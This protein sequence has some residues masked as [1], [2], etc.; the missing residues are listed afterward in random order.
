MAP[1]VASAAACAAPSRCRRPQCLRGSTPWRPSTRGSP[2]RW[3]PPRARATRPGMRRWS[4]SPS[5]WRAAMR[6]CRRCARRACVCRCRAAES[7]GPRCSGMVAPW[8]GLGVS[9]QMSPPLA[10]PRAPRAAQDPTAWDAA[11]VETDVSIDQDAR[12]RVRSARLVF[13]PAEVPAEGA[14]L[15]PEGEPGGEPVA[16]GAQGAEALGE[17]A[18]EA[19]GEQPAAPEPAAPAPGPSACALSLPLAV[20]DE[21][22]SA[23]E[24]AAVA[25]AMAL[26]EAMWAADE[27]VDRALRVR[28]DMETLIYATRSALEDEA[29]AARPDPSTQAG[30]EG[31]LAELEKA[32]RWLEDTI[33]DS[34]A[35]ALDEYE[36]RLR[37]LKAMSEFQHSAAEQ[38]AH[39]AQAEPN[40]ASAS[41]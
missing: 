39:G 22:A 25:A 17:E 37:A 5:A 20:T 19:A 11:R 30:R 2:R 26:E 21:D 32:E 23:T 40:D 18:A 4:P 27:R 14:A 33:R 15:A 7:R 24:E 8:E 6:G 34:E 36:G 12:M 10:A 16:E 1:R 28:N 13:P 3:S 38:S 29:D 41:F 31:L 9:P 35:I